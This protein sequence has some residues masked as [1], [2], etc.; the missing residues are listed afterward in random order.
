MS[1]V[2]A[3]CVG[4]REFEEL[5]SQR[6]CL[7]YTVDKEQG[8]AQFGEHKGMEEHTAPSG[9][10]LQR[11][12]Q[13]WEGIRNAPGKGIRHTQNGGEHGE[14]MWEV[15]SLAECQ[16]PFEQGDRPVKRP[17]AIS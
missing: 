17:L 10:A 8:L 13:E 5:P 11:L 3:P 7:I 12:V 1:L 2:A 14:D 6:A 4:T 9:N 15:G 16:A